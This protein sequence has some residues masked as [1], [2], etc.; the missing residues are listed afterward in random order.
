[1]TAVKGAATPDRILPD[2]S[3]GALHRIR[4]RAGRGLAT[5]VVGFLLAGHALAA[6]GL[7][8]IRVPELPMPAPVTGAACPEHAVPATEEGQSARHHCPAEEPSPQVRVVDLPTA[9]SVAMAISVLSYAVDPASEFE[10]PT[11]L[12][13]Q[14]PPRPLYA[15]LQRLRL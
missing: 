15:R 14:A 8:A 12:D 11:A 6:T 4:V 3:Q 5:F 9:Q 2:M 10:P 7:C 13:R 1:L